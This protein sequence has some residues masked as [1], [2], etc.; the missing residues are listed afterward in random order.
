MHIA[1]GGFLHE[2]NT[3]VSTPT[4]WR[5]FVEPSA[6]PGLTVGQAVVDGFDAVNVAVSGFCEITRDAH[7]LVGTA[8]SVAQPGG[9][10]TD[11]AFEKMAALLVAPLAVQRFDMVYLELHGAMCTPR[12]DDAEGELLRRVREAVGPAVPILASLD[13]HANVTRLMIEMADL[14]TAYRTYPHVDW[15]ESGR[16]AARLVDAV[17]ART[18]GGARRFRQA[19]FLI[20]VASGCTLVEPMKGLYEKLEEIEARTGVHLSF[21]P[22]F[23]LADIADCGPSLWGYG[24]DAQTT[25]NA[26]DELY[27][28]LLAAEQA[29]LQHAAIPAE[30][31]V[32][33]AI[34]RAQGARR[35]VIIADTQDNPGGGGSGS[36]TG[37]LRELVRQRAQGAMVA[38]LHEPQVAAAAHEAGI[39]A[40][41]EA[42]LGAYVEGPGQE[43]YSGRFEVIA[44]SD[45]RFMGTGPM[46]G[47]QWVTMGPT[48]VL[49]HQGIDIL[50]A[51][52]RQQ[53]FSQATFTHLGIDPTTRP[54]LA[55]KSSVHFRNH[56]QEIAEEVIV[57]ASAG[58][59]TDDTGLVPF[60]KL[61]P[62][63]R[64]R[65]MS[66][67]SWQTED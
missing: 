15:K 7:D 32:T 6:W 4:G 39:G 66:N 34:A 27:R 62:G 18:P 43:P 63:V 42:T 61:R 53:P 21:C 36:T 12:F 33:R 3:F 28:H 5:D 51:T 50:V 55:L 8:W 41:I 58:A 67:D 46:V 29:F 20:P 25:Q 9:R 10:V 30:E 54:I 2:T 19:P 56:F 38:I 26:V 44:L 13:L 52:V 49:R 35:P 59:L 57:A 17:R 47:G 40:S 48:A 24:D 60:E 37:L 65:P 11:E 1:V 14:L 45:G 16:R 31:A 22:G 23:P 64:R